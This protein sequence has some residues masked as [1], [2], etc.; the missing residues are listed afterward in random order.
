[1]GQSTPGE[2]PNFF[3]R[4]VD[5]ILHGRSYVNVVAQ[6]DEAIQSMHDVREF[7]SL[8]PFVSRTPFIS[9]FGFFTRTEIVTDAHTYVVQGPQQ[10]TWDLIEPPQSRM[11]LSQRERTYRA[12]EPI[13]R[14]Y[15]DAGDHVFVDKF[16]Y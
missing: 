6:S 13:A 7:K 16:T 9:N 4:F 11:G 2:P 15:I 14:G 3:V 10:A 12:G 8:L 5:G 1:I